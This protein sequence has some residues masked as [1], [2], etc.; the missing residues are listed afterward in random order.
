MEIESRKRNEQQNLA[1][2]LQ[3]ERLVGKVW[4]DKFQWFKG[5]KDDLMQCG[6]IGLWNAC[7]TYIPEKNDNFM[8]Y[9]YRC[10][11][12]EMAIYTR[13]ELRYQNRHTSYEIKTE[14]GKVKNVLEVLDNGQYE[15]MLGKAEFGLVLDRVRHK[16]N[17]K[18]LYNG[19]NMAEIA[20]KDGVTK[21][22]IRMRL[23]RDRA[24][25]EYDKTM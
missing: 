13:K 17:I 12:N 23:F 19:M 6:R 11:K 8:C 4:F 18:D 2:F 5:E 1:L 20:R 10:I 15:Q 7:V 25:I 22:A 9:A 21:E 16:D 24:K 14:D 3:Y